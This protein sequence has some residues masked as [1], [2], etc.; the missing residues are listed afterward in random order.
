MNG[1]LGRWLGRKQSGRLWP[2]LVWCS[3]IFLFSQMPGSGLAVEPPLWYV[4]ERKSAHVV[5]YAVLAWLAYRFF[6]AQYPRET[7]RWLVILTL[8]FVVAY[9]TLDEVHQAFVFGR[10]ARFTDV[11]I[12][13]IGGGLALFFISVLRSKR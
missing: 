1:M 5:E 7:H 11:M 4:L 6:A 2:L 12:D 10:G 9:G 3:V 13:G 8:A